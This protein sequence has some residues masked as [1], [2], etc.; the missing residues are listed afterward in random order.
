MPDCLTGSVPRSCHVSSRI[1]SNLG[2][3]ATIRSEGDKVFIDYAPLSTG[4]GY[5][6]PAVMWEFGARS[7]G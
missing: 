4:T 5:V 7:T 6:S 2:L 1:L 3:P